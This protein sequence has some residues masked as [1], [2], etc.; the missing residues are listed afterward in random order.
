[1]ANANLLSAGQTATAAIAP[2]GASGTALPLTANLGTTTLGGANG[3]QPVG[4]SL[5]SPTTANGTLA[6]AN[7]LSAG[8]G[9]NASVAPSG[10]ANTTSAA[11]GNLAAVNVANHDVI[12]GS[13]PLLG[14]SAL[15]GTQNSGSV[16][17]VGAAAASQPVN[18]GL[19]GTQ[20]LPTGR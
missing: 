9:A 5:L 17:S 16:A 18:L 10:V 2:A 8:Q 4:V 12:A 3:S 15:S 11:L 20:I 14:V 1:L 6:S 19:G 7:L 13:N